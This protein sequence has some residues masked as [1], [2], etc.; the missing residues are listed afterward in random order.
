[1]NLLDDLWLRDG[2]HVVVALYQHVI[3]LKMRDRQ[4]TII[5]SERSAIG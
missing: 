3:V 4:M 2:K 5:T 1:M